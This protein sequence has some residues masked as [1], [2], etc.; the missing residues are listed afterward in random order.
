MNDTS[1]LELSQALMTIK[2]KSKESPAT[3]FTQICTLQNRFGIY[4][5]DEQH[6]LE[7]FANALP[8]EYKAI[9]A[10]ERR[11][12]GGVI[13][14][15]D[16]EDCLEEFD[17]REEQCVIKY[18]NGSSST[19]TVVG[20]WAGIVNSHGE[21]KKVILDNVTVVPGSAYNLFSLT[22]VLSEGTLSS[23]GEK[24][25]LICNGTAICFDHRIETSLI[26]G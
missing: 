22:R 5:T 7:C 8:T 6:L 20:K 26:G 3:L 24:M 23:D 16:A 15:D 12:N 2:M 10:A 13:T 21:R 9:L 19:S 25:R 18:G 11:Q 1:K 14:M 4:D 17:L